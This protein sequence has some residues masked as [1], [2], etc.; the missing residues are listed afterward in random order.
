MMFHC[1]LW[2]AYFR[3]AKTTQKTANVE[4]MKKSNVDRHVG[5]DVGTQSFLV[6][7]ATARKLEKVTTKWRL[8]CAPKVQT[9]WRIFKALRTFNFYF[10]PL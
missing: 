7:V 9:Y 2:K 3:T 4:C 8:C 1:I 5:F 10:M 6:Q